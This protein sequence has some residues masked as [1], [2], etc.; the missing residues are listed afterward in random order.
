MGGPFVVLEQCW[1]GAKH[2]RKHTSNHTPKHTPET[3]RSVIP[4]VWM[5]LAVNEG[6][7]RSNAAKV[8]RNIP[9]A[10]LKH[11]GICSRYPLGRSFLKLYLP[12]EKSRP[13]DLQ[14][15][16]IP[17][18]VLPLRTTTTATTTAATTTTTTTTTSWQSETYLEM[19]L[20][21]IPDPTTPGRTPH[22]YTYI[23]IYLYNYSEATSADLAG[24]CPG[25]S[26]RRSGCST[27]LSNLILFFC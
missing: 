15:A 19:R 6:P 20:R 9:T 23:Y 1:P 24:R 4:I 26:A 25:E 13:S 2:T 3:Y 18:R 16:N 7:D 27:L 14:P 8:S 17:V 5:K 21:N 11:T 10:Y 22:I 12:S